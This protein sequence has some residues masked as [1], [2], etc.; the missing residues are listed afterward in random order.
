MQLFEALRC[1]PESRGFD[2]RWG[3]LNFFIDIIFRRHCD[4]GVDSAS[5][6]NEYQDYFLRVK[7]PPGRKADD[8]TTFTCRFSWYLRT[9]TSW[10]PEGLPKL[11]QWLH[12][13]LMYQSPPLQLLC[14][15]WWIITCDRIQTIRGVQGEIFVIIFL[16]PPPVHVYFLC[17]SKHVLYVFKC[18][19][20]STSKPVDVGSQRQNLSSLS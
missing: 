4:P 13:L 11:V 17:I 15:W 20:F 5:N 12:Y 2:S 6:R 16:P 19:W 1:K 7:A 8:L 3:H 10:N 14:W 9:S 18:I